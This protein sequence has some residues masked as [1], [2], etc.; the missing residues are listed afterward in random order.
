LAL[1]PHT[2]PLTRSAERHVVVWGQPDQYEIVSRVGKG[3]Y[4]EVFEAWDTVRTSSCIIKVLKPVKKSKIKREIKILQ[5]IHSGPNIIGLIEVVR[6]PVSKIPS[7]IMEFVD[8]Q[9]FKSL[10]AR[11]AD[12]DVRWYLLELLKVQLP[13]VYMP[14]LTIVTRLSISAIPKESCT[15][16]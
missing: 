4:S 9:D 5:N 12:E 13:E 6:D 2:H 1:C 11:F 7:L 3:K 8:N 15:V 10:Y 16:T 14:H